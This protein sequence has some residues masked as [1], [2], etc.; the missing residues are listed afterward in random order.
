VYSWR[1]RRVGLLVIALG[2]A[3]SSRTGKQGTGTGGASGSGGGAGVTGSAGTGGAAGVTG[4][5]GTGGTA[6]VIGS[7]GTGGAA[8]VTGSAGTGNSAG[9]GGVS[10]SAGRGGS[11]AGNGGSAG[12][13]GAAGR[14]GAA[15]T[16]TD[17]G[18]DGSSSTDG[19]VPGPLVWRQVTIPGVTIKDEVLAIWGTGTELYVGTNYGA[20]YHRGATGAW[21][22]TMVGNA[23]EWIWGSGPGDVY[24]SVHSALYHSTGDDVWTQVTL[25]SVARYVYAI[26]GPSASEVFVAVGYDDGI[27]GAILHLRAGTWTVEPTGW[28]MVG[29]WGSSATDVWAIGRRYEALYW[30][31][32]DG[33]WV[34]KVASDGTAHSAVWGS[35]PGDVYV[36]LSPTQR[37]TS[38]PSVA[39]SQPDGSFAIESSFATQEL[40]TVWGSGPRDVYVAGRTLT[41]L[42]TTDRAVVYH[43]TGDGQWPAL[44]L[45]LQFGV[46]RIDVIWGSSASD[47]YMGG[48]AD[49][50]K[51][52]AFLHGTP[53]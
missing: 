51:A 2:L 38:N 1:V 46:T 34:H 43:S 20:M 9:S 35:G 23:I 47:V 5:A 19:P 44:Q 10:G 16:G 8:G 7:A 13:T 48:Y 37:N 18:T 27:A 24:A 52:G 50:Y 12:T 30:S 29:V 31:K 39:H 22:T 6:G 25:P 14:G 49:A 41:E 11:A 36:V 21:T 42:F 33:T 17:A 15:G 26:W 53:N 28:L 3:C 4:S 40:L 45:P 32:G